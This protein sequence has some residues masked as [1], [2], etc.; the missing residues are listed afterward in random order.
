MII[1]AWPTGKL[2]AQIYTAILGFTRVCNYQP[3]F[4]PLPDD[5]F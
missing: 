4:Y 5:K 3:F 1:F 2:E